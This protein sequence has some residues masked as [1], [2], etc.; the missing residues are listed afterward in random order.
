MFILNYQKLTDNDYKSDTNFHLA[1]QALTNYN[2]TLAQASFIGAAQKP[3]G[4]GY[5]YHIFSRLSTGDIVKS[6]VFLE[7]FSLKATI[8][9]ISNEDFTTSLLVLNQGD[10]SVKKIISVL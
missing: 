1:Y 4:L 10:S 8:K 6:E 7:L 5:I 2:S 9:S 3:Q